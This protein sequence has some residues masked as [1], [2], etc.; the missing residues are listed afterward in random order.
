MERVRCMILSVGLPK[1]FLGEA[2]ST[3]CYLI[4]QCT[5]S[6]LNFK[7]PIEKWRGIP[8]EYKQ[9]RVFGCLAYAHVKQ[10]NLDPKAMRC[11]FVG[12]PNGQKGYKVWNLESSGPRCFVTRD[13]TFDETKMGYN[14]KEKMPELRSVISIES[15]VE[16]EHWMNSEQD[17]GE[18]VTK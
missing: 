5:S 2:I 6:A 12:Y 14:S 18:H 8:A 3:T 7:T 13:I 4:N 9:L 1:Y 11:I 10:G 15:Q 16:V 17:I